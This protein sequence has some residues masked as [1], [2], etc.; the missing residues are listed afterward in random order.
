MLLIIT[1]YNALR[2]DELLVSCILKSHSIC[3]NWFAEITTTN[4]ITSI[5][6][7][8]FY[9]LNNYKWTPEFGKIKDYN[10]H[11]TPIILAFYFIFFCKIGNSPKHFFLLFWHRLALY[12]AFSIISSLTSIFLGLYFSNWFLSSFLCYFM[13]IFKL[14]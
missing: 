1:I 13:V 14:L 7:T 11:V 9:K 12:E 2:I 6:L 3:S 8:W 4:R 10:L 5:S